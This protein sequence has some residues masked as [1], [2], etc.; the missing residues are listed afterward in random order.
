MG[1]RG[2]MR[3]VVITGPGGPEVLE[4]RDV[5]AP[6]PGPGEVLVRVRAAGVNRADIL[7]RKGRYPAPADSPQDIPGLEYAGEVEALGPPAPAPVRR[8]GGGDRVMGLVGGGACA[9]ALV[10]HADTVLAAPPDLSGVPRS[11][12]TP[13]PDPLVMAAAIPEVFLT[14]YDALVLQL[15]MRAGETVLIHAVSSGVGTAAVQLARAW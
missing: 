12:G 10:A 11:P 2:G 6:V 13:A 14:A 8:W 1:D 4:I 9:E 5:P 15:G 7:Q 3:A